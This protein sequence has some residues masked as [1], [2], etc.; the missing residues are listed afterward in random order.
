LTPVGSAPLAAPSSFDQ[1]NRSYQGSMHPPPMQSQPSSQQSFTMSQPSSQQTAANGSM[2]RQYN[3]SA[4]HAAD[5]APVMP[6]YSVRC[7][8]PLAHMDNTTMTQH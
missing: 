4:R 7:H 5:S 3:D 1:S 2:Y 6:I 8:S